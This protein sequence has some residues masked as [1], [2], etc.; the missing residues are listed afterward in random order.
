MT[1]Q[2]EIK[3]RAWDSTAE[4]W[5]EDNDFYIH[6]LTGTAHWADNPS[7]NYCNLYP[8]ENNII[9]NQFTGLKDKNGIDIYEGDILKSY[10]TLRIDDTVIISE[11]LFDNRRG[12]W[13]AN[14]VK[15]DEVEYLFE[16]IQSFHETEII[17]NIYTNP[18]LIQPQK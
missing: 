9:I 10:P 13:V 14:A 11:V 16:A 3:F 12:M 4:E 7:G 17:G 1:T 6:S 2:R 15:Y 5:T 18:E 8:L